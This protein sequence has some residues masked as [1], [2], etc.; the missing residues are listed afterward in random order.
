MD[1]GH[2]YEEAGDPSIGHEYETKVTKPG[3]EEKG[4]TTYTCIHCGFSYKDDYTEALVH[5]FKRSGE[6]GA[7]CTENGYN[8]YVCT[9]CGTKLEEKREDQPATGHSYE[10]VVV[11]DP[12]CTEKGYTTYTCTKKDCGYSYK[13]EYKDALGHSYVSEVVPP[14]KEREGYTLH[15]CSVCGDSYTDNV[16]AKLPSKG[17]SSSSKDKSDK[18]DDSE[19]KSSGSSG[20]SSGSSSSGNSG[21][22]LSG[23]ASDALV[24]KFYDEDNQPL[25]SGVVALYEGNTQLK[26]WS[27]TYDNVAVVDNLEKYA[28]DNAVAAY[29]LKQSKAMDG[30]EVSKDTFT[31]QLQKQSGNLKV[32]VKKNG[33]GSK[34]TNVEN[35]RDGKPIV[36]FCNTKETTQFAIDCQVSVEFAGNCLPD[37]MMKNEYLS[38]Q[39]QFTLSWSDEEGEEKTESLTLINGD[40]G[41]W[42]AKIPFGTQYSITATD[43][44]GNIVTGL[45]NNASGTLTAKQMDEKVRVEALI[46]YKVQAAS[47][48][49]LEMNVVD[50]ESSTPLRGANF[51]LKDPDGEKIATFISRESGQFY[52]E[53][54]FPVL[55]DYLLVQ[56]KA[57]EGYATVDGDIPV[58]VS[59]AYEQQSE[60]N[61]QLLNQYKD[62][63]FAHQAVSEEEDG[64][65]TIKNDTYDLVIEKAEKKGGKTG[66]IL[67]IAGGALARATCAAAFV[68]LKKKRDKA[69]AETIDDTKGGDGDEE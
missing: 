51:E 25:N 58:T 15:T 43:P 12:T 57:T 14:T 60:N 6:V 23:S 34:G 63:T 13:G 30:Y 69:D 38:K 62:V 46:E 59:L 24:V 31:V 42:K 3:C 55:G 5:E 21:A 52:M 68:V 8:L 41:S 39:Y 35:G 54:T 4:Y 9:K 47:P 1:C 53:D 33:K 22:K 49:Q 37:E 45:S 65:F 36:S 40:S 26:S 56:S 64:S 17:S 7:T 61:V 10:K 67:G 66:M 18:E 28:K 16:T 44:D 48:K 50:G 2:T 29:T 32:S 19:N 20:S 27:C 11:T